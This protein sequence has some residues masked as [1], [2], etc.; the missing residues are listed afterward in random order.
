MCVYMYIYIYMY[1]YLYIYIHAARPPAITLAS[2]DSF[3]FIKSRSLS[4][5]VHICLLQ[6]SVHQLKTK[7]DLTQYCP[8]TPVRL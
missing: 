6:I 3:E 1:I 7:K 5:H 8:T 4:Q 2:G